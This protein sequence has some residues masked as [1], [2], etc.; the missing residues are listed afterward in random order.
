M[1]CQPTPQETPC[2]VCFCS[3]V[4][5]GQNWLVQGGRC[6]A[7]TGG[8]E[9]TPLRCSSQAQPKADPQLTHKLRKKRPFS[10]LE[11]SSLGVVCYP[12]ITKWHMVKKAPGSHPCSVVVFYPDLEQEGLIWVESSIS[13]LSQMC[14]L[15]VC[16][17]VY[18]VTQS[19]WTL[20]DLMDC[21]PPGSSLHGIF[22][23]KMLKQ[24]A[25]FYPRVLPDMRIET[26][27]LASLHWWVD[28]LPLHHLGI[29]P[30]LGQ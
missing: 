15:V 8:T 19:C 3:L 25:T 29:V 11:P 22:Q 24:V 4:R 2:V 5:E 7:D 27:S 17:C 14:T 18:S 26:A 1:V 13:K 12:A 28:S 30:G 6:E 20:C 16:V 9:L 21:S 23:A 10:S